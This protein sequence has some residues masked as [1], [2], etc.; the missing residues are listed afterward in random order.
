MCG[1][2]TRA[3]RQ[4]HVHAIDPGD[5]RVAD[6]LDL[7]ACGHELAEP[8]QRAR[9]DVHA[10]GGE[11]GSVE[12]GRA[13]VR[14]VVVERPP[15]LE[16]RPERCFVLGERP[17]A[18]LDAEPCLLGVDL[19]QDRHGAIAQRL[20]D[21]VGADGAAAERD[22]RRA[23]RVEGVAGVLRLAEAERGLAAGH[24]DLRDRLLP[25]D[26]AVDVDERPPELLRERGAERRLARAHEADQRDVT[27]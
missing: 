1:A 21:L 17:V 11:H 27:T 8:L 7:S 25:L 15:L 3:Q 24:E 19:H 4:L 10:A 22:H 26:L 16:Q 14:G 2:G 20:P 13:G 5:A 9:F 23:R 12:I 18:A 6:D